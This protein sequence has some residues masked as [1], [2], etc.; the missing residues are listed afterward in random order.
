M[1]FFGKHSQPASVGYHLQNVEEHHRE[2]PRTFSIPRSEQRHAL[3]VGQLVKLVFIEGTSAQDGARVERMW[4]EVKEVHGQQ[5]T[6]VLDNNPAYITDLEVGATITFGPE[7]V[8]A[9]YMGTA[10]PQLPYGQ[11]VIVN[12]KILAGEAWPKR[13]IRS[14]PEENALSGWWI[15]SGEETTAEAKDSANFAPCVVEEIIDK[16]RVLDSV[17]DEP[18]GSEWGWDDEAAEYKRIERETPSTA[19]IS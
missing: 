2:Y 18:V 11:F 15:F 8:A 14:Q 7:H 5:Y 6:G 13:L 19:A 9:L 16:Y 10:G 4:V 17:L 12:K 1:R 3:S